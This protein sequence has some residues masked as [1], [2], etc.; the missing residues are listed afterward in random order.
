MDE[1]HSAFITNI[2]LLFI[3]FFFI[4]LIIIIYESAVEVLL[5]LNRI[6]IENQSFFAN[7][8]HHISSPPAHPRARRSIRRDLD[9]A[10]DQ[11]TLGEIHHLNLSPPPPYFT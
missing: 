4:A 10:S 11:S 5:I 2:L 6:L 9:I 1:S 3:V 8:D 7:Y